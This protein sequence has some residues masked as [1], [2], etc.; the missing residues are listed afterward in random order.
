MITQSSKRWLL[1]A[2][3][4]ALITALVTTACDPNQL[5]RAKAAGH[6]IERVT[7]AVT[8]L[9]P[10]FEQS[11]ELSHEDA[12]VGLKLLADF[13]VS[14][15]EFNQRADGYTTFDA[16]S[17]ADLV[18]LFGDVS[19]GLAVLNEQGVTRIKNPKLKGRIQIFLTAAQLAASEISAALESA[20]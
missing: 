8:G 15:H 10:T 9:I 16:K 13:K 2:L 19:A 20:A 14:I 17:K 11:G 6:T 12:Q 18:K 7:D 4:S 1:A 3:I 5:K